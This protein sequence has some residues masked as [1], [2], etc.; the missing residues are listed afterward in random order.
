M[1]SQDMF[2]LISASEFCLQ[3]DMG[4]SINGGIPMAGWFIVE[5][6]IKIDDLGVPLF[7]EIPLSLYIYICIIMYLY[8]DGFIKELRAVRPLAVGPCLVFGNQERWL[9]RKWMMSKGTTP[10]W[11]YNQE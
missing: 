5:N 4:V 11:G 10:H 2:L 3:W 1:I 9:W 7:Q 6:H 8:V